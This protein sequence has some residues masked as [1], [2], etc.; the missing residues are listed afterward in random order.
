MNDGTKGVPIIF[1]AQSGVLTVGGKIVEKAIGNDPVHTLH[2]F[3]DKSV[4]EVFAEDG[5]IIAT[6]VITTNPD[7]LNVALIADDGSMT[8]ENLELWPIKAIW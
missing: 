2:F 3:L 8:L 1:D 5:R 4:V 7:D 6:A